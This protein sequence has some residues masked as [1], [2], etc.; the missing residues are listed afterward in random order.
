MQFRRHNACP[1]GRRNNQSDRTG[2]SWGLR[3][4]G[5]P[6]TS[7]THT[8]LVTQLHLNLDTDLEDVT[9]ADSN[10]HQSVIHTT[11]NHPFWDQTQ[12]AWLPVD[13][14]TPGDKLHTTEG[15]ATVQSIR[16]TTGTRLMYNLTIAHPQVLCTRRQHART[17]AQHAVRCGHRGKDWD[18][19][20]GYF[21]KGTDFG[22]LARGTAGR[23]GIRQE[24]GNIKYVINAGRVVGFDK[25]KPTTLYTV[26]RDPYGG[27]LVDVPWCRVRKLWA[28]L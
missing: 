20:A 8:E 18:P 16:P 27:D 13:H 28:Y 5:D 12:Q 10:G 21:D 24:N 2:P 6:S 23:I 11:Q 17:R 15:S 4:I 22:A 25:G 7:S 1:D 26:I 3:Q 14:L 9:V 19:N